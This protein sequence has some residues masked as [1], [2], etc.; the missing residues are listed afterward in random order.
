M[1]VKKSSKDNQQRNKGYQK[2]H[3]QMI[4]TAIRLIAE[5]GVEALSLAGLAREMRVN[6]TTI[7]YHFKNRDSLVLEV[8][9]WASEQLAKGLDIRV[10][11][12]D[13]VDYITR[14]VLENP[15]L[16][17]MWIEDLVS[18]KNIEDCYPGW[19]AFVDSADQLMNRDG[20]AVDAE[21]FCINLLITAFVTPLVFTR[22]I[23]PGESRDNLLK[24]FR[25]EMLRNL[26][27]EHI[28]GLPEAADNA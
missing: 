1:P 9:H 15:E 10:P 22:S 25:S 11:R 23:D 5:K 12:R 21:I 17:K 27:H 4:E 13:R 16:I 8:K 18:G 19:G 2:S 3:Q 24:R 26:E 6:R 14:F 28:L 7:Y 20:R